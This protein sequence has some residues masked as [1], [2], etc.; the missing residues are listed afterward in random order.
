MNRGEDVVTISFA[1]IAVLDKQVLRVLRKARGCEDT[2]GRCTVILKGSR[3][4]L[5]ISE[6][7]QI[8]AVDF[9]MFG[10]YGEGIVFRVVGLREIF[11]VCILEITWKG[12][13]SDPIRK[14]IESW[15]PPVV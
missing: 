15:L 1:N 12:A 7:G 6:P 9:D 2:E 8:A 5:W 11:V 3:I 10:S 4:L 14:E 13:L